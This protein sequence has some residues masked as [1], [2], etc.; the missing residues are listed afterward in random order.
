M[1]AAKKNCRHICIPPFTALSF[2]HLF[3]IKVKKRACLG[4]NAVACTGMVQVANNRWPKKEYS[5]T[6]SVREPV[7]FF[8]SSGLRL[9]LKKRL[10]SGTWELF[11]LICFAGSGSSF[12]LKG[13]APQLQKAVFHFFFTGLGFF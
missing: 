4:C 11:L 1:H 13:L 12:L 6:T 3:S 7:P 8:T 10:A 5:I 9:I 2:L